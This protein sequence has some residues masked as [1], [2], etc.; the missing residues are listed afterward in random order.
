MKMAAHNFIDLTGQRFGRLTVL[1]REPDSNN[2]TIWKCICDCGNETTVFGNNLRRGYTQSC[3]C[4]QQERIEAARENKRTHGCEPKRLYNI[5]VGMKMRCFDPNVESYKHYGGRGI[6][7]CDEWV[8]NYE[9]FRDWAL[10]NG[11]DSNLSIDRVDVDGNYCPE[12]CRWSTAKEQASNRRKRQPA[13]NHIKKI[14]FADHD[15]WLAIRKNYIGGSDAGSVVSLNPYSSPYALWAEKTGKVPAF[16][17]NTITE[18]GSFLEE[19]VA[20]RFTEE[21]GK[22]V[23]KSNFTYVNEKYPWACANVDRLVAG[24][25]AILEIKTTGN[26]EYINQIKRGEC[27]GTWWAQIIHYMTVLEKKKAYLAVLMQS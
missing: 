2:M 1:S 24:E 27:V 16:E 4:L 19:Y 18:V 25:D 26:Y 15:E 23:F 5:W 10:D 8:H 21:T 11:Y 9:A 20:K 17:G 6:T 3:G 12:N 13:D 14:P 7:V 22:K